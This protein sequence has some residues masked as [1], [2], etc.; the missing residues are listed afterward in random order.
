[1]SSSFLSVFVSEVVE[2]R[3]QSNRKVLSNWYFSF[4][5]ILVVMQFQPA[6]EQNSRNEVKSLFS[7]LSKSK[8]CQPQSRNSTVFSRYVYGRNDNLQFCLSSIKICEELS[9]NQMVKTA[10]S[11]LF[12]IRVKKSR[13]RSVRQRFYSN[14]TVAISI[15]TML[16]ND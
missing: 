3:K 7:F 5:F 2:K 15:F 16:P 8:T 1:M 6:N 14:Y 4:I 9:A 10:Q 12:Q 13:K 11:D